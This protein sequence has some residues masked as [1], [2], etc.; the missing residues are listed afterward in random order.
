MHKCFIKCFGKKNEATFQFS[1]VFY[2]QNNIDKEI[3]L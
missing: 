2:F 1:V 3:I